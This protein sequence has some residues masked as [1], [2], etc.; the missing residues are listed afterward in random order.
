MPS[1]FYAYYIAEERY[2]QQVQKYLLNKYL[3]QA[4]ENGFVDYEI[5]KWILIFL[6]L[7]SRHSI[8]KF[9]NSNF[10]ILFTK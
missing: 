10:T 5:S 3:P 4:I 2:Y 8:G 9:S 1:F 7:Y 6:I